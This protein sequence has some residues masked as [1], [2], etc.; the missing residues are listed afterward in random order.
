MGMF[1]YVEYPEGRCWR[2]NEPL[3][4]CQSKDGPR[5][6]EMLTPW[7]VKRFYMD[8]AKC[9]AW[10]EFTVS[11]GSIVHDEDIERRQTEGLDEYHQQR[12]A[13]VQQLKYD[14]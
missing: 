11:P 3:G 9:Y 7:M 10:N 1:D 12:M 8:C 6:L 4:L 5:Q 2:C 13:R 14:Q